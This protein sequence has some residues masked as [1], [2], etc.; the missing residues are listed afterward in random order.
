MSKC[1]IN[2]EY[3]NLSGAFF[4]QKS[5][6]KLY[7]GDTLVYDWDTFL[8][9]GN[10]YLKYFSSE[11]TVSNIYNQISYKYITDFSFKRV[12]RFNNSMYAVEADGKPAYKLTTSTGSTV[13]IETNA[14]NIYFNNNMAN[15]FR[16]CANL[17]MNLD[18]LGAD[19]SLVDNMSNTFSVCHNLLGSP[20]YSPNVVDMS[21]AYNGCNNITGQPFCGVK[22]KLFE[23]AYQKCYNLNGSP[24]C[25][26]EV[27]SMGYSYENCNNLIGP[28]TC[29]HNVTYMHYTYQDCSNLTGAPCIG[30]N[31]ISF[32]DYGSTYQN[33]SKLYGQPL[34]GNDNILSIRQ[35]YFNVPNVFGNCFLNE[36]NTNKMR[37]HVNIKSCFN[38]RNN[39]KMLNI[40]VHG[41]YAYN[42]AIYN[43]TAAGSSITG[44]AI[45]WTL[46]SANNRYYNINENIYV[47]YQR[48]YLNVTSDT[49][50]YNGTPTNQLPTAVPLITNSSVTNL[51]NTFKWQRS[52]IGSPVCTDS[53]VNMASAYDGCNQLT[54]FPVC[55][56]N[57][58]NMYGT[59]AGCTNLVG[60]P[61]VGPNVICMATAYAGCSN[62][63][64]APVCGP[65]TN[66][67]YQC[68]MQCYNLF[69]DMYIDYNKTQ[70]S[71]SVNMDWCFYGRN[72]TRRLNIHVKPNSAYNN[73]LYN[74]GMLSG[75][76]GL[77]WTL[78]DN[79]YY[80]M[81]TNT[82]VY[83]NYEG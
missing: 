8:G 62:L 28:S 25:G 20:V 10:T 72:N 58:T 55:G 73:W 46:D 6:L 12:R 66:N 1:Y 83:Y 70:T 38:G 34:F 81:N 45:T 22:T 15:S 60:Q 52:L 37:T 71:S 75:Y 19:F 5:V 80:N 51:Y 30:P 49:V 26:P 4:N 11:Q 14:K 78:M 32:Y 57:V 68:Y 67:L 59:Y 42:N 53:I 63:T 39:Q 3:Q 65:N 24:V 48:N 35:M 31:V 79:G 64:G 61:I 27:E 7:R 17:P 54:G 9:E 16:S 40:Y 50:K 43:T 2:G 82:Y 18:T 41:G 23:H 56:N 33:C 74:I 36:Q 13:S 69:G 29:G 77:E 21:Y 47:Y 76:P 44:N